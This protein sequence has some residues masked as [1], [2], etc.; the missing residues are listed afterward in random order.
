MNLIS[1]KTVL[2]DFFILNS[3]MTD[4]SM[5]LIMIDIS[6]EFS[7]VLKFFIQYNFK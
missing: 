4:T 3:S 5:S 7:I 6:K 2:A 1:I